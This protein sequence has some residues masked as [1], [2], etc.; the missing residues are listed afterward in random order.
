[1]PAKSSLQLTQY[2][3]AAISSLQFNTL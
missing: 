3:Q 2:I 1:L